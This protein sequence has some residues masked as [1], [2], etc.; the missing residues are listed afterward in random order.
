[1]SGI[2]ALVIV[3][4]FLIGF[5]I[6]AGLWPKKKAAQQAAAP[7]RDPNDTAP[8]WYEVLGVAQD[9][10]PEAIEQAYRALAEQY[11]PSKVADLGPELRAL[12]EEKMRAI[13]EAYAQAQFVRG[14][15]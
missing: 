2:D 9:A 12:A 3:V 13:D 4:F 6:V 10:A 7:A 5:G 15:P 14:R 8:R 1:M 11:H